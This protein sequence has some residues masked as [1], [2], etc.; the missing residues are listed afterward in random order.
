MKTFLKIVTCF[1]LCAPLQANA[2]EKNSVSL[3]E[4]LQRKI[5]RLPTIEA[6]KLGPNDLKNQVV[7]ISFFASWCPPC[8]TEFKHLNDFQDAYSG[9][10]LKIIA[11]NYFED[12][13]GFKDDGER[14][15]RFIHRHKPR[16]HVLKGNDALAKQ[17]E[18][19]QRI[20][21]VFIFDQKGQ[22]ALHF[23]HRYKSKKTNPTIV[24]LKTVLNRLLGAPSRDSV[25]KH[26]K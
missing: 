4:E 2:V 12:L 25:P 9:K 11:I 5:T 26:P 18:D 23:I 21:T 3:T 6:T 10:P 22:K 1:L 15:A 16:F 14:L 7:L 24:E 13:G 20:P 17:F 19:V 8:N